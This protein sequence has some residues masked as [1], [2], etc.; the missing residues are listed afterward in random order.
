MQ[1]RFMTMH[2]YYE[3]NTREARD[4][5]PHIALVMTETPFSTG[6]LFLRHSMNTSGFIA[7]EYSM[8]EILRGLLRRSYSVPS[9]EWILPQTGIG[10]HSSMLEFCVSSVE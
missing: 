2:E 3:E 8:L 4:S 9:T 10:Y 7:A 5:F 6:A 1:Q